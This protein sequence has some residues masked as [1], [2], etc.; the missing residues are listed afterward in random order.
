MAMT[1]TAVAVLTCA[2]S[3]GAVLLFGEGG[4]KS[5][6]SDAAAEITGLEHAAVK[7]DLAT[8][9]SFYEGH[10]AEN[11]SGGT[12]YG[13]WETKASLLRDM[14]DRRN[15]RMES[16]SISDVKVRVYGDAAVATYKQGYHLFDHGRR[17]AR[18]VITTDT[19]VRQNGAWQKVA[20]HSSQAR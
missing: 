15:H 12:S 17:H 3:L 20:S 9:R 8:D 1:K 14:S 5:D 19:W 2:V 11:W 13:D 18:T 4:N 7:A 6:D 10:L 16:E